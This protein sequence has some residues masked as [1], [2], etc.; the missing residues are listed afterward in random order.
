MGHFGSRPRL[1]SKLGPPRRNP[2]A[3]CFCPSSFI[4]PPL[5]STSPLLALPS[6]SL[7][8]IPS[9][10]EATRPSCSSRPL[11]RQKLS[12]PPPF[13]LTIYHHFMARRIFFFHCERR[14]SLRASTRPDIH[15]SNFRRRQ[16]S[17]KGGLC[18][19]VNRPA[20]K[21]VSRI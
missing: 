12:E 7:R 20:E 9:L 14:L 6:A 4:L 13:A 8:G 2:A 21:V 5:V 3:S 19:A 17:C 16:P 11:E 1:N 18:D 10:G 15:T